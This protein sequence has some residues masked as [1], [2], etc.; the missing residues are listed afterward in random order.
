M[1]AYR[2][3]L[4]LCLLL[5]LWGCN[6]KP[7][8]A[9]DTTPA[10]VSENTSPD[11]TE[12]KDTPAPAEPEPKETVSTPVEKMT[13][14]ETPLVVP[15]KSTDVTPVETTVEKS[16][17][18]PE[19]AKILTKIH[20][21][22]SQFGPSRNRF[23]EIAIAFHNYHDTFTHF[24]A[25]GGNGDA[26]KTG[27][28]WRVYLLPFLD[29]SALYDQFHLDEPWDSEHNK[30]L[31]SKM[32]AV[33]G[34]NPEGKTN[35]QVFTGEN[36]PFSGE[37]GGRFRDVID[38]TSNTILFVGTGDDKADI[39]TKPGGLPFDADNPKAALGNVK[40]SFLVAMMDG[41]VREVKTEISFLAHLI[42]Q[43]DA[44]VIPGEFYDRGGSSLPTES[45]AELAEL[46]P[47]QPLP[48]QF[49]AKLIPDDTLFAGVV[50]PRH[51]LEHSL[52][53][54]TVGQSNWTNL[55]AKEFLWSQML[56]GVREGAG[57]AGFRAD[58]IDEIRLVI[59]PLKADGTAEP[60]ASANAPPVH[61]AVYMHSAV[62]LDIET[63]AKV[64]LKNSE[65]EK[66]NVEG[67]TC[68]HDADKGMG[69]TFLGTN[70]F[71]VV[72]HP[73]TMQS[74]LQS[75]QSGA[76]ASQLKKN[77]SRMLQLAGD[78]PQDLVSG[79][80]QMVQQQFPPAIIAM[81]YV[82]EARNLMLSL[83]LD[84]KELLAFDVKMSNANNATKLS[85]LFST[86][87]DSGRK[88][89]DAQKA[90]IEQN[91]SPEL[92]QILSETVTGANVNQQEDL[93]ELRVNRPEHL[94]MLPVAM[95]PL[96]DRARDA[97]QEVVKRND[98]KQIGLAFHNF[99]DVY[100]MMPPLD[101]L[102]D[103]TGKSPGLSWRV[104]LL[105]YL[106]QAPLY[107][108][109]HH[110]EPWDSEHN[111]TLIS[112][113]PAIFGSSPEGKTRIHALTGNGAPFQKGVGLKFQEV[114]D[115]LSNT[116]LVVEAGENTAEFW[117]KPDGLEF[118]PKDPLK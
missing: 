17:P 68:L 54:E 29:E 48:T 30:T 70:E 49:D 71:L 57:E 37:K 36:T 53:M 55:S 97:A 41:S 110:D 117:T 7:E 115:G 14:T 19:I 103:A 16:G 34:K 13:P 94:S 1:N 62:P 35:V 91:G 109:F 114:T 99:Y 60:P 83:D 25:A 3:L 100:T 77:G 50:Y 84:H 5:V 102:P 111:K 93:V 78:I 8:P 73:A 90:A 63:I 105:P 98:F 4:A 113:M 69:F 89:L 40:E 56:P 43:N 39:W 64:L 104:A 106:E 74:M 52:V 85:T 32:P 38:G 24:P 10:P 67:Y 118:D 75:Q 33:Y 12:P 23:K 59:T 15:P 20:D 46:P 27:L 66:V 107:D 80:A 81:L 31:I 79:F 72:D 96:L 21:E 42:Q 45:V 28:S 82:R 95:K 47:T 44:Q 58:A 6:Q 92:V 11:S 65:P 9:P 86:Q 101:G 61:F 2:S 76:I 18:D 26:G 112:R 116:I 51:V 88:M 87:L 22:Y 108:E